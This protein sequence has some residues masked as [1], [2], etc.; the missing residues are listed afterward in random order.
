MHQRASILGGN[1]TWDAATVASARAWDK[2]IREL[3][4]TARPNPQLIAERG[5]RIYRERYRQDYERL[6]H[7]KFVAIDV[8]TECTYFGTTPIEAYLQGLQA[9]LTA[10]LYLEKVGSPAA[11]EIKGPYRYAS[12]SGV[13]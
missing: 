13:S 7:G 4:P 12:S 11:F 8:D 3:G 2:K 5:R 1:S 9:S 10:C 6:H